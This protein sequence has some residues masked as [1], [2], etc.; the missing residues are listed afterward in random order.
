MGEAMW[1]KGMYMSD[2]CFVSKK[3]VSPVAQCKCDNFSN[4]GVQTLLGPPPTELSSITYAPFGSC[5]HLLEEI[6]DQRWNPDDRR[7]KTPMAQLKSQT[8]AP[9]SS[10]L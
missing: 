6:T 10:R 4:L 7:R 9:D 8:E 1:H 3:H 2:C 5:Y